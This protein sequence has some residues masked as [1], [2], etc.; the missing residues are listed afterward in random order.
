MPRIYL[1]LATGSAKPIFD[2]LSTDCTPP[3]PAA[4]G[5]FSF[6]RCH[7]ELT[8]EMVTPAER[9]AIHAAYCHQ[10]EWDFRQGEGIAAR[11]VD[12]FQSDA[13]ALQLAF[14][15]SFTL[16][17]TPVIFYGDEFAKPND[18]QFQADQEA[19]TGYKDARYRVRGAVDWPTVDRQLADATS[20]PARTHDAVRT[21]LAVRRAHPAFAV[22]NFQPLTTLD[23][24]ILAYVR[25]TAAQQVLVVQN[26]SN[27]AVTLRLPETIA[28]AGWKRIF[29][30]QDLA[31][32]MLALPP[33]GFS[34]FAA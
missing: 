3:I 24:R 10:P 17:G 15:I 22:G 1:A 5:W 31:Q 21:M 4:C 14:S 26:L 20:L 18:N 11:L 9:K 23:D 16:L 19:L 8:L 25:G 7:D 12:L 28:G 33:K 27:D 34:W 6:L 13:A 2:T 29:G 32:G 30:Q